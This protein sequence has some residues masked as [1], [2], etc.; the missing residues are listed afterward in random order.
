M[1]PRAVAVHADEI[2]ESAAVGSDLAPDA[3]DPS[4]LENPVGI[5]LQPLLAVVLSMP[6][7]SSGSASLLDV[8]IARFDAAADTTLEASRGCR[9]RARGCSG[10]RSTTFSRCGVNS[11]N[12]SVRVTSSTTTRPEAVVE[13]LVDLPAVAQRQEDA[14]QAAA[15]CGE[16]FLGDAADREHLA[17]ECDFA[18]IARPRTGRPVNADTGAATIVTPAEVPSLGASP[19]R[20]RR[21]PSVSRC[22]A[23]SRP[24]RAAGR[25]SRAVPRP[26]GRRAPDAPEI[27]YCTAVAGPV[28]LLPAPA[29]H[30][31]D[32]KAARHG[33]PTA[34][35]KR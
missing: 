8:C 20:T 18:L 30:R 24:C 11:T 5:G 10:C 33:R 35:R 22:P 28:D 25:A 13:V 17:V 14:A 1:A 27:I 34:A 32:A 23:G 7:F 15:V 3:Q 31:A 12:S 21:C 16:H 9:R 6:P 4:I 2:D 26:D 19:E 29:A